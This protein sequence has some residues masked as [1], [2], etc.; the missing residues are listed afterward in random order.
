M[1][2][3]ES[4]T[5]RCVLVKKVPEGLNYQCIYNI[6]GVEKFQRQYELSNGNGGERLI[7]LFRSQEDAEKSLKEGHVAI[8]SDGWKFDLPVRSCPD[9][10]IPDEWIDKS[11]K[12]DLSFINTMEECVSAISIGLKEEGKCTNSLCK[13][14]CGENKQYSIIIKVH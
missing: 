9:R 13:E 8:D 10:I 1:C 6:P 14:G 4:L 5:R 12:P 11:T 7:V 3:K 2:S